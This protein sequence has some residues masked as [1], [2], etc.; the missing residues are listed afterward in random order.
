[1]TTVPVDIALRE[2]S[3]PAHDP[4][5]GVSPSRAS[6]FVA[7]LT[8]GMLVAALAL[9]L[10]TLAR[11]VFAGSLSHDVGAAF[12]GAFGLANVWTIVI[13]VGLLLSL[14]LLHYLTLHTVVQLL[15]TGRPSEWIATP[16]RFLAGLP[17]L[18]TLSA[19]LSFF[20]LIVDLRGVIGNMIVICA[21]AAS[22]APTSIV[23]TLEA[24][25]QSRRSFA[26]GRGLGL[27]PP[28]IARHILL[29][30]IRRQY[31]LALGV[32]GARG[33]A[34]LF[35]LLNLVKE[36]RLSALPRLPE[37]LGDVAEALMANVRVADNVV[38]ILVVLGLALIAKFAVT[39][40]SALLK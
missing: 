21:V 30:E 15:T 34:E 17:M 16:L 14:P 25:T 29:R 22:L 39:A 4:F 32:A 23:L 7:A 12:I 10:G 9:I 5:D 20:S 28:F 38:L 18:L 36:R 24:A 1:M 8:L 6:Q 11:G 3:Q 26:A 13:Y 31:L 35:I 19:I 37:N 27:S 40:G 33:I 2:P